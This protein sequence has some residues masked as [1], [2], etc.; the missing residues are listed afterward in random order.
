MLNNL[1]I[2]SLVLMVILLPFSSLAE[3][4]PYFK[5]VFGINKINKIAN[6]N[7][8][9]QKSNISPY[10]GLGGGVGYSFDDSF[11]GEVLITYSN[12]TFSN[13]SKPN[14]FYE[15]NINTKK[16]IINSA[17]F[18]LYKDLFA[19]S[20]NINFF[21]GV[22]VGVS[23]ISEFITWQSILPNRTTG[24]NKITFAKGI[25]NR[26][27]VY[28][29]SHSVMAGVDFK[30]SD[31]FNLEVIYQFKNNGITPSR[32]LGNIMVDQKH[33]LIHNIYTGIRYNL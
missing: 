4:T 6:Y 28:N 20:E 11:R 24:S 7:N 18:N 21:A 30:V 12:L 2:K 8:T 15:L 5:S 27:I 25:T 22:G 33:Y 13:K 16:V 10:F 31:K 1:P 9:Y 3:H 32:K 14:S 26:K 19:I 23:Q 29:F 17:M